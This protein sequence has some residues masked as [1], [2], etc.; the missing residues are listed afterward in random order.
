MAFDLGGRTA[1][2]TGAGRSVGQGIAVAL[3]GAGAQ[4]VVNDLHADRAADTVGLID[5]A[6][7]R[8]VAAVFDVTD[9]DAV[10]AGVE[11]GSP[12]SVRSTCSCTTPGSPRRGCRRCSP[13]PPGRLAA[14]DRRQPV[15]CPHDGARR[16]PGHGGARLRPHR[17]DLVGRLQ[18][19]ARDRRVG[20]R[21]R[22][23]GRREPHAPHR[24]GERRRGRHGELVGARSH[25]QRRRRQQRALSRMAR[26]IPVGRLGSPADVGAACVFLASDEAA[27]LTGQV[28]HLNGGTVFGR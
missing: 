3:A 10:A 24:R 13:R 16:P 1:L 23:G 27:W 11:A 2:V 5:A 12:L 21:C 26:S 7:G 28:I 8:A 25:G 17:A 22:E 18:P 15:R 9:A 20:L 19:G 14:D 6:G 4:V